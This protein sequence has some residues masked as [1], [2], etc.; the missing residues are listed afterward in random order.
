MNNVALE[1]GTPV[2]SHF[3]NFKNNNN[4]SS[5]LEFKSL[6]KIK[7]QFESFLTIAKKFVINGQPKPK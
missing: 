7:Y 3:L 6:P 1:R 5:T 4:N 2:R